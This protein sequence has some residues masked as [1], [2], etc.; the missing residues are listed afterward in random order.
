[1][2]TLSM[3]SFA[4]WQLC[5]DTITKYLTWNQTRSSAVAERPRAPRVIEYFAKSLKVSQGH[6]KKGRV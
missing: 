4:R 5:Y 6:S 1:M 3:Q 2:F